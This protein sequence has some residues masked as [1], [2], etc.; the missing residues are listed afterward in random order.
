MQLGGGKL[1]SSRDVD[2]I[3][4]PQICFLRLRRSA[5]ARKKKS[6]LGCQSVRQRRRRRR[7]R[8]KRRRWPRKERSQKRQFLHERRTRT[9]EIPNRETSDIEKSNRIICLKRGTAKITYNYIN[10]FG[11][12]FLFF[13]CSRTHRV[14]VPPRGWHFFHCRVV[15]RSKKGN[16]DKC[17][18][19]KSWKRMEG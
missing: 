9:K 11:K 2:F 1:G 16:L 14:K 7:R 15:G 4:W 18:L 12:D 10:F 17:I 6:D 19:S 5:I 3:S 13:R 8:R